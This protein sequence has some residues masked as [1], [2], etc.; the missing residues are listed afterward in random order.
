MSMSVVCGFEWVNRKT[1]KENDCLNF[2]SLIFSKLD[3]QIQKYV[4]V[5]CSLKMMGKIIRTKRIFRAFVVMHQIYI[6]HFLV[7]CC[8]GCTNYVEKHY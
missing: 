1:G 4:L 2:S 6:S 8:E 7:N 3:V 5:V